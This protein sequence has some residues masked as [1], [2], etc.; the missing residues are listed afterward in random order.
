M[1]SEEPYPRALVP[2]HL[3][4]LSIEKL[5]LD[6]PYFLSP[7]ADDDDELP[8]FFVD[9]ERRLRVSKS[10]EIDPDDEFPTSPFGLVGIMKTIAIDPLTQTFREVYVA[11]LRFIEDHQLMDGG[12]A[13]I[14]ID[15]QEDYMHWQSFV[16]N[17]I[18]VDGFIAPEEGAEIDKDAP[19]GTLYGDE[20]LHD[21]LK[22]LRKKGNKI[23]KKFV[24]RQVAG[25]ANP[26]KPESK[27]GGKKQE[28]TEAAAASSNE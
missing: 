17:C 10:A 19:K 27:D 24:K 25:A 7:D 6:T 13:A 18:A 9:T 26:P 15:D 21:S 11:D 5:P 2:E 23:M 14:D 28:A 1:A 22:F 3:T 20:Q 8:V 16:N 4:S 12:Q